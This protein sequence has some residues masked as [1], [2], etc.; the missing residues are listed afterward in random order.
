[1]LVL[2]I[3]SSTQST[4]ALVVDA[5]DGSVVT[6]AKASHPD[7]TEVDPAAWWEAAQNA[8]GEVV[9]SAPGRIEAVSVGGQQHGMVA[10]DSDGEP[11]RDALLWNDTRSAPQAEQLIERHGADSLSRRTGSVP[12][13]SFTITKLAWLAQNEPDNADR[14]AQVLLPHDWVGWQLAGRPE[15][16]WTDHGDASGTG[17][18]SP[19]TGEWLPDLLT[20]AMGGRTPALPALLPSHAEAARAT[21]PGIEGATIGAGT[22]DN[23]A[24]ALGLGLTPGDVAVSLGTSGAV[25]AP[26]EHAGADP[27][28]T[29]AGFCDA[30][31]R[32]LPLVCTL[33]AAR[34]LSSTAHM[35]DT[36]LE[37]LSRLALAAEPGAGGL[38]LLP[39]LEGERTP[40]L[41]EA[42]GTLAGLTGSNMTPQNLARAAVE[43]MLC[44]MADAIDALRDA[45]GEVRR[46]L[47]I[48]GAGR[49]EAVQA[50]APG[51]FGVDVDVPEPAEYVAIGAAKQAAW[52]RSG[53]ATPPDWEVAGTRRTVGD[54]T[55]GEAVRAAYAA[56]RK[57]VHGI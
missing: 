55:S 54:D 43:G 6:E 52:A 20:E 32:Y 53:G 5:D 18:Y 49:S 2:G 34:V 31:G 7:G 30:T 42:T 47:L 46:V 12:V 1:M 21:L 36:D 23:M 29:V 10:L 17:Y 9:A 28:G 15:Q 41:P 25:F 22:G 19:T 24:A 27:S 14:V 56:A 51:L 26:A 16:T 38:S 48:G 35:L 11:V 39:Y 33:N 50:I 37:G 57:Q 8:I 44:G 3:D 40:N 13:A 45:G 4:K